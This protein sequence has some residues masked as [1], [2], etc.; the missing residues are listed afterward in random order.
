MV[1]LP[2]PNPN[3]CLE[4][5]Y[6]YDICVIRI[7][8]SV[9]FILFEYF[10]INVYHLIRIFLHK[11]LSYSNYFGNMFLGNLFILIFFFLLFYSFVFIS[12]IVSE[13]I[14]CA[15]RC[16]SIHRCQELYYPLIFHRIY[17]IR[18]ILFFIFID[19][20][21]YYIIIYIIIYYY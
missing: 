16:S 5:F 21:F 7:L 8:I 14:V 6:V 3:K 10:Y 9:L 2:Y 11:H 13:Q 15:F 4:N 17:F 18:V 12:R 20:S 1:S 19:P